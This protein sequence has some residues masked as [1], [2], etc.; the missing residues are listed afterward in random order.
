M[1]E[2]FRRVDPAR[3][4]RGAG[5]R[6]RRAALG[7]IE[8]L[9]ADADRIRSVTAE[10][11]ASLCADHGLDSPRRIPR[12]RKRLYKRYL[13]HCLE[14]GVLD[15]DESADLDHLRDLLHLEPADLVRVHETVARDVYG[16]AVEEVLEDLK[17]D[18]EE[19]AFLK[20]LRSDLRLPEREAA[21][22]YDRQAFEARSA[23]L[24]RASTPDAE[25]TTRKQ[26]AGEFVGRSDAGLEAA[27]TDA[28]A[29]ASIAIPEL[30][31]FELTEIA[32]YVTAGSADGWHVSLR[33]GIKQ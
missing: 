13:E 24:S 9:L 25:M 8:E 12:D 33:A 16:A 15:D 26:P 32:G 3:R 18:P 22:L 29:K 23:A 4:E 7:A 2:P 5:R 19:E 20:R 27:V 6:S 17:L 30:H 1:A 10:A 28:L 11:V 14:D 31:W 21:R